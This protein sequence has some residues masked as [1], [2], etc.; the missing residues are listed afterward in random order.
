[1]KH[2]S[3]KMMISFLLVLSGCAFGQGNSQK[4]SLS[5]N[6]ENITLVEGENEFLSFSLES[7]HLDS[8]KVYWRSLDED[9]ATVDGGKVEAIK[10]GTTVVKA[11]TE[12]NELEASCIVNVLKSLPVSI[13]ILKKPEKTIFAIGEEFSS[14][15]LEVLLTKENGKKELLNISD[16]LLDSTTFIS[17]IPG[18]YTIKISYVKNI[19]ICTFF[20]VAVL[21]VSLI[22][23]NKYEDTRPAKSGRLADEI[24]LIDEAMF[25]CYYN[26]GDGEDEA[27]YS[28]A[29]CAVFINWI[30][31]LDN[32]GYKI[33]QSNVIG[34]NLFYR[35]Y[36]R[37]HVINAGF[38]SAQK[39]IRCIISINNDCA[40]F[41]VDEEKL[42]CNNFETRLCVMGLNKIPGK[43]ECAS[44][45][46]RLADGTFFV[47][48]GG[49][50]NE[51]TF[52]DFV[53]ALIFLSGNKN[54]EIVISCW[55]IT[56]P[57]SDHWDLLLKHAKEF[58]VLN[59][60]IN[61]IMYNL[62]SDEELTKSID[63]Y[64]LTD[65]G[66]EKLYNLAH[67]I[68]SK[69]IIPHVGEVFFFAGLKMEILFTVESYGPEIFNSI[70]AL[71]VISK[72][73]FINRNEKTTF[74]CVG[75]AAGQTLRNIATTF[76]DAILSDICQV[77]HHGATTKGDDEGAIMAYSLIKP[78]VAIWNCT[79]DFFDKNK[80]SI[81]NNA[82]IDKNINPNFEANIV[83]GRSG[84]ITI[85][86][87]PYLNVERSVIKENI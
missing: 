26:C 3:V 85:I 67:E 69:I 50:D 61:A 41:A 35:I 7:D 51:E 55:L 28:K 20:D 10:E 42:F 19:N 47:I 40:F 77:S 27:I 12:N 48:D 72:L 78:K 75:D 68:D 5:L 6:K 18:I 62:L 39:E 22:N 63:K 31:S 33:N 44:F 15:G 70:N 2:H 76:G 81:Y 84:E 37:E 25:L 54:S 86:S 24:P 83:A 13:E 38:Y 71:S 8:S 45:I 60:K 73:T 87:F 79:Q 16:V 59:I 17:D 34:D 52:N 1:M 36:D 58:G 43:G 74:M 80:N 4:D 29:N 9:I 49:N 30:F 53:N 56:H 23:K 11:I 32:S 82:L 21:D 64:N 46:I 66:N 65:Y 14:D 57:H